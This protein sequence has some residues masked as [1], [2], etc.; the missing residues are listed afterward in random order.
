[1]VLLRLESEGV[2]VDTS[3]RNV[4]VVLVRLDFVEVASLAN[5]ESVV[6]VE[7]EECSDDRVVAGKTLNTGD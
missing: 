7:L 1:M 4:G 3:G 2:D 6:A 5:L